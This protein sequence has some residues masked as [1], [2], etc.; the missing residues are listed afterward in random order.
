[1]EKGV[2][3]FNIK[4]E[5]DTLSAELLLSEEKLTT[6]K[7]SYINWDKLGKSFIKH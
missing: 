6:I 5:N 2:S 3:Y 1:M 7:V 4:K